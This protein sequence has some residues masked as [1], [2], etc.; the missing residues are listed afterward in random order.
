MRPPTD[1]GLPILAF[2]QGDPAGIGPEI[3]LKLWQPGGEGEIGGFQPLLIA[4][5]AA[6]EPLRPI[7]PDVLWE[8]LRYL[9]GSPTRAELLA[10]GPDALPVLDPVGSARALSF[11]QSGPADAAGAKIGRAHV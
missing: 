11:G 2:T 8:R 6:L 1:G 10:L 3:L 9:D 4:E 7:L 5:R